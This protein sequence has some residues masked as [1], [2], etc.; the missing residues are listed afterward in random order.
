[1]QLVSGMQ[2][3]RPAESHD[4][5]KGLVVRRPVLAMTLVAALAFFVGIGLGAGGADQTAL[6]DARADAKRSKTELAEVRVERDGLKDD[7]SEAEQR[8]RTAQAAVKRL[9]A[10]G[11][12]PDFTGDDVADARDNERVDSLGWKLR[13]EQVVTA[14]ASPGT[15]IAQVPKEGK[16]LKSGRSIRLKVAKKPPPKPKQWVTVATLSGASSTKTEEFRVPSGA[17]AR[18]VYSMPQDSNNA[19]VLYR[20]P[21]EYIDLLLNEIGPQQGETRL[22]ESGRFYLDVTGSYSIQVQVFKRPS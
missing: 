17:K 8:A 3:P 22:Y 1:M 21:K 20:A 19:I 18:L 11:E 6:D 2:T 7:L 16:V 9:S 5:L 14:A 10:K 13:T 4:G 15:V 12:V